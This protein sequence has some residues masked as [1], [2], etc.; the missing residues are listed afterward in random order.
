MFSDNS[1]TE[2]L[3]E[4]ANI[5]FVCV[6]GVHYQVING[7]HEKCKTFYLYFP[8]CPPATRLIFFE[9]YHVLG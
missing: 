2:I 7:N 1:L 6:I 5:R 4:M 8:T 9:I 3:G